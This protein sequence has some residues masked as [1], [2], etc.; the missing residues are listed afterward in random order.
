MNTIL[1]CKYCSRIFELCHAFKG[2]IPYL[3]A[4]PLSCHRPLHTFR[5]PSRALDLGPGQYI[6]RDRQAA[7]CLTMLHRVLLTSRT[8]ILGE[9][10]SSH[11]FLRHANHANGLLH[12]VLQQN[13][14]YFTC[15]SWCTLVNVFAVTM[16]REDEAS[17][18]VTLSFVVHVN[19]ITPLANA[20]SFCPR[21]DSVSLFND[22]YQS[23]DY[24]TT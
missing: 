16:L 22:D 3:Y 14:V 11:V 10:L 17:N 24:V 4:L 15:L 20:V 23:V 2:P 7:R 8:L 9:L 18:D 5:I 19:C 12:K 1:I 6:T 21:L 13:A